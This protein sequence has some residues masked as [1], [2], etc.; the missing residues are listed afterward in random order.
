[1]EFKKMEFFP[2]NREWLIKIVDESEGDY[3]FISLIKEKY[4][5]IVV[6]PTNIKEYNSLVEIFKQEDF[7]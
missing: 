6:G 5:K 7:L 2:I 3:M 1:M 4:K